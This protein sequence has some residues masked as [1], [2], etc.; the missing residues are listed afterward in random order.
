MQLMNISH[1]FCAYKYSSLGEGGMQIC[2]Y[3]DMKF[4]YICFS[5]SWWKFQFLNTNIFKVTFLECSIVS[6]Y[7]LRT[8]KYFESEYL[9]SIHKTPLSHFKCK[10]SWIKSLK[11]E[12]TNYIED[13]L[14]CQ[15]PTPGETWELTLLSRGNKN[16]NVTQKN[17]IGSKKKSYPPH[18]EKNEKSTELSERARN[19]IK[20]CEFF[21]PPKKLN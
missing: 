20:K 13:F 11:Y 3:S 12:R 19:W 16:N 10:L 17:K 8:K 6:G 2:T 4:L 18:P 21:W 9:A 5:L 14:Y 15:T 7:H 1:I